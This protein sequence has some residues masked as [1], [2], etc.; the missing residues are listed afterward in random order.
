MLYDKEQTKIQK[1]WCGRTTKCGTT[2]QLTMPFSFKWEP[3]TLPALAKIL[4]I[5]C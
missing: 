2:S 4:E 5:E 3:D 1:C